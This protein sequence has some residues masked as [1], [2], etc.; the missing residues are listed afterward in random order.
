VSAWLDPLRA[1]LEAAQET[2]VF[3]FRDDDA[4][5]GDD[6]LHALLDVYEAA[7]APLD[8]AAIPCA[9]S[10]PLARRL[11]AR[12]RAAPELFRIH[13][14][15]LAHRNHEPVGHKSEFG[16]SRPAELQLADVLRGRELLL[17]RLDEEPEPI[18]TPPWNRCTAETAHAVRTAGLRVLSRES[19]AEP[20]RVEAVQELPVSVDW[21]RRRAGLRASRR[22]LGAALAQ[23]VRAG[24][25]TGVML[26]HAVMDE[27]DRGAI[28]EL[29]AVLASSAN[30]RVGPMRELAAEGAPA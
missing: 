8:L 24:E 12:R 5:W 26:H 9:L 10:P 2:I 21:V 20:L 1:A 29:L 3:F 22:E 23:A 11:G 19:R 13:Q 14:H 6:R 15:G 7:G 25:P 30:V 28:A 17:A 27:A 16:P 4:G 18:F